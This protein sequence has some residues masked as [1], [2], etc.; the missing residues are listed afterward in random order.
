MEKRVLIAIALSFMVLGFYPMILQKIYPNYKPSARVQSKASD[1]SSVALEQKALPS[2]T[3]LTGTYATN[4]DLEFKNDKFKLI[5]NAKG[6]VMREISFFDY[7]DSETKA[8]LKIVSD[9]ALTY[10][11]GFFEAS[12]SA[13]AFGK[14]PDRYELREEMGQVV[15]S[16]L[17]LDGKLKVTKN[18][19][20]ERGK[21]DG[22]L[23]LK[24]E[25]I[26]GAPLDLYYRLYVGSSLAPRH[27]IDSQYVEANF[28]P[29]SVNSGRVQHINESKGGKTVQSQTFVEWVATKST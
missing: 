9:T 21:Y 11:P 13:S 15:L 4:E 7:T 10:S 17:C 25:N 20:F 14:T 6:G 28:F 8:P 12:L 3:S 18:Y 1:T 22:R 2:L 27:S 26:S 16:G 23:T 19:Y 5:F 29:S 24:L